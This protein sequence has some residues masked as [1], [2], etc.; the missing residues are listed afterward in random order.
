MLGLLCCTLVLVNQAG[1]VQAPSDLLVRGF[2]ITITQERVPG[3]GPD[4]PGTDVATGRAAGSG[5][6]ARPA[7]AG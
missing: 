3:S 4:G 1:A 5:G 7:P 2:G 6:G